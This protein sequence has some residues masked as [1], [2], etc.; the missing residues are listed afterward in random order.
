MSQDTQHTRRVGDAKVS[1]LVD[2][3]MQ[4]QRLESAAASP[5]KDLRAAR[6]RLTVALGLLCVA[7]WFSPFPASATYASADPSLVEASA[8][9]SLFLA[10]QRMV[11]FRKKH[12][13]LPR[14]AKEAGVEAS[15]LIY[16]PQR[17]GSLV[18]IARVGSQTLSFDSSRP[19]QSI[20]GNAESIIER[21]GR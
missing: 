9:A 20:L 7:A 12:H 5:P 15:D 4:Q 6:Q 21:S 16:V 11:D 8:R 1:A 2:E 18:L 13:R 14:S 3:F 19:T 10:G 17:D